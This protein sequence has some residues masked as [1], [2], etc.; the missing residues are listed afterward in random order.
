[1]LHPHH[2][3]TYFKTTGWTDKWIDTAEALICT[4]FHERYASRDSHNPKDCRYLTDEAMSADIS[5]V[6]E[7]Y[8]C[9]KMGFLHLAAGSTLSNIFNNLPALAPAP[10]A[11]ITDELRLYLKTDIGNVS[12]VIHWWY[13]K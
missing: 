8:Y 2:K 10:I 9:H 7:V 11:A 1:M 6:L 12:D 13:E 4:Q 3:L 5:M